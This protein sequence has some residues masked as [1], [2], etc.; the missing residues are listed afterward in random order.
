MSLKKIARRTLNLSDHKITKIEDHGNHLSIHLEKKKIRRLHCSIC[1]KRCWKRDELP[2]RIWTHVALWGIIV[3]LVY[4]P[5]RV[6][7]LNCGIKVEKIPWS[8]GKSPFS[9]PLIIQIATLARALPWKEVAEHF[10]V[11]WNTVKNCVKG[12]VKHGLSKRD[13]GQTR[14][15]GIDEISRK[16][17]HVYLTNVYDLEAKKLIWSGENR[18]M[19]TL[20]SF[21]D[22]M[23]EDFIAGLEGI[24]C[25]MW[26]P[27]IAVVKE[28]APFAALVL[29]KF[30]IV[31]HLSKAIDKVRREEARKL[32]E[33]GE[34]V[35]IGARYI[36]LKNPENLTPKQELRLGELHKLNLKVSKAYI[37]KESFRE[38]WSCKNVIEAKKYLKQWFWRATHSRIKPMRDFAWMLRRHEENILTWFDH[39]I[40]NGPTEA[41]NNN[42][43]VISHRARG[44]RTSGTYKL[45]L[46]HCM[47]GLEM[48]QFAHKYF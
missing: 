11:D 26:D 20:R 36:F 15:I 30:H 1:N 6:K 19:E 22:E 46:M 37:L 43:K 16:K 47:G 27:Y 39:P 13:L 8:L 25:D 23:G 21:F 38:F 44:Y 9:L 35:L 12:A 14:V 41:M 17:G 34:K 3:W 7:C 31:S 18:K 42:A 28:R 29:D 24:C 4:T 45:A 10:K 40:S 33:K 48:P 5:K 2:P 32:R